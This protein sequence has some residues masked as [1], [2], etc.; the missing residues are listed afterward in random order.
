MFEYGKHLLILLC[1]ANI[2]RSALIPQVPL[3]TMAGVSVRSKKLHIASLFVASLFETLVTAPEFYLR[4][5][6]NHSLCCVKVVHTHH[7]L[8]FCLCHMVRI[9]LEDGLQLHDATICFND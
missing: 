9:L 6:R 4:R 5:E 7:L 1:Y 2:L 8:P 3:F